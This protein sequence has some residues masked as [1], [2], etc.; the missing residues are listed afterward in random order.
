MFYQ[1]KWILRE[2]YNMFAG[3]IKVLSGPHEARRP[4]V[5]QAWCKVFKFLACHG[6]H[7]KMKYKF[8]N[9]LFLTLNHGLFDNVLCILVNFVLDYFYWI[10]DEKFK[11]KFK[12]K[13][14]F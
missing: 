4:D 9:T 2:S 7:L 14:K 11:I 13:F 1:S 12:F 8:I 3:H 10:S 5:A 6:Y